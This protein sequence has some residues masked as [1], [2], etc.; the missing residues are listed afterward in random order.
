MST[1]LVPLTPRPRICPRFLAPSLEA[2]TEVMDETPSPSSTLGPEP[3]A[4]SPARG[5]VGVSLAARS[6]VRQMP[7]SLSGGRTPAHRNVPFS[8]PSLGAPLTSAKT[9]PSPPPHGPPSSRQRREPT[10]ALRIRRRGSAWLPARCPAP[11]PIS[12][13]GGLR[14]PPRLRARHERL[15]PAELRIRVARLTEGLGLFPFE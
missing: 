12:T 15:A 1:W 13:G 5:R 8:P 2:P 6:S 11:Q 7:T 9:L 3:P 14:A 4:R 10:A